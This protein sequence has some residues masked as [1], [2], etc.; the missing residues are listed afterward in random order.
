MAG[1]SWAARAAS[2]QLLS[3]SFPFIYLFSEVHYTPSSN[4]GSARLMGIAL[5]REQVYFNP[6]FIISCMGLRPWEQR[7]AV[8]KCGESQKG[9]L[10]GEGVRGW[11]G[12]G[13][14]NFSVSAFTPP[15]HRASF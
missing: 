6:H 5:W 9:C 13:M 11:G 2:K 15:L 14:A 12:W 3:L 10:R 7:V 8:L 4:A 1:C